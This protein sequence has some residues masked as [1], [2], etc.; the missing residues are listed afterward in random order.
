MVGLAAQL[1]LLRVHDRRARRARTRERRPI[2][3]VQHESTENARD[4]NAAPP[5]HP[6]GS[7]PMRGF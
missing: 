1:L 2:A 4:A 7:P 3:S 5:G 6:F